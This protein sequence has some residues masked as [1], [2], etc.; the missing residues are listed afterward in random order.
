MRHQVWELPEIQPIVT[1]YQRH[2]LGCCRCGISTCAALPEGVPEHQS[3]PRL[4]SLVALLM[5]CFRQSKRRV[6]L[7]LE[8]ILNQPCSPGLVVKLQ[9][10]AALALRPAYNELAKALPEQT[11]LNVDES[12]SKQAGKKSWFWT[13]V[14]QYFTVFAFRPTRQA[15]ILD[16]L[17]TPRFAGVVSCDRAKMYWRIGIIQWCWAHLKRDFQAFSDSHNGVAK[18]LGND[19]LKQTRRLFHLWARC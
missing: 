3:G 18:R 6:A 9:N 5:T 16:E 17:L 7:F 10:Q 4:T 12:P 1:E 19:L 13:F 2:R 11:Q 15:T 8:A 14:A